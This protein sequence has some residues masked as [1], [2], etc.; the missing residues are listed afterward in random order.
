MINGRNMYLK[1]KIME[2]NN[3]ANRG[4]ALKILIN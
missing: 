4:S 1:A 3:F 2:E